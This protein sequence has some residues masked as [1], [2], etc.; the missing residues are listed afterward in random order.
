MPG[1]PAGQTR[2]SRVFTSTRP[3]AL[4]PRQFEI[5]QFVAQDYSDNAIA[6]RLDLTPGT[7][8]HYLHAIRIRL[9]LRKR[10]DITA[11]IVRLTGSRT[12]VGPPQD[13]HRSD[14]VAGRSS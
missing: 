13:R 10:S 2:T 6:A 12:G 14:T 1:T 8:K 5:A 11:W 3:K 7:V 4:T 9:R